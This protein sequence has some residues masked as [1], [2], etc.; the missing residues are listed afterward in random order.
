MRAEVL[1]VAALLAGDQ[2]D[3]AGAWSRLICLYLKMWF[4]R[5]RISTES[6][7]CMSNVLQSCVS[8]PVRSA[9]R[10]CSGVVTVG[11]WAD[12][13]RAPAGRLLSWDERWR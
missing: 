11:A 12:G 1:R 9:L 4:I 2:T 13:S 5:P 6:A 7:V 10:V 3:R 8:N